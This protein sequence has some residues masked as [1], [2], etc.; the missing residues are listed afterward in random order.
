[1][2]SFFAVLSSFVCSL[3]TLAL[4][5]KLCSGTPERKS[6]ATPVSFIRAIAFIVVLTTFMRLFSF[7]FVLSSSIITLLQGDYARSFVY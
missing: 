6:V 7:F 5:I 3:L 1:M 4:T 2:I